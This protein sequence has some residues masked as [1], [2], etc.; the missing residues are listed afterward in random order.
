MS[1]ANAPRILIVIPCYNEE[2]SIVS[3]VNEVKRMRQMSGLLLDPLVVNDCSTDGTLAQLQTLSGCQYLNL[4][5]NL[6]I[7]GAM[8]AGYRYAYRHGYDM[9]VQMDGDGQHP[10]GELPKILAPLLTNEADVVIGS[11]FLERTGFQSTAV[12]RIGIN[13]FRRLNHWLIGQTIHDSTS[14]FRAFNRR[15]LAIVDRYYPDEYPEPEAIVQFGLHH[16]R[17]K[18]VP[19]QMRER[20]GGVSSINTGRAFYY[21][22]K[23]TLGILFVYIRLRG[24]KALMPLPA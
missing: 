22:L 5:V 10:A 6:G 2:S 20:Q 8:Q 19:V 11:R 23:V 13:Y 14:G 24:R 12:R 9:A 4:P 16:L 15:T 18:E 7:G 3:V 21:M 1:T 17:I